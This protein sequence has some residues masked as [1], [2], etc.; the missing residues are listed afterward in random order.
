M[1][2]LSLARAVVATVAEAAGDARVTEVRLRIGALSGVVAEALHFAFDIATAGTGA[3]GAALAVT[4]VPVAVRCTPCG[5]VVDLP[6]TTRFRCPRCDTPSAD[7][8]RGRELEVDS[9]VVEER[10]A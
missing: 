8:V 10:V 1:H 9:I 2:E 7:V 4:V 6:G 3:D 5:E